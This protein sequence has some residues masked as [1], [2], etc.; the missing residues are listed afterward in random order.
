MTPQQQPGSSPRHGPGDR[1][2]PPVWPQGASGNGLAARP[3]HLSTWPAP[4][5]GS[6][7]FGYAKPCPSANAALTQEDPA[8]LSRG[9]RTDHP[10]NTRHTDGQRHAALLDSSTA[11][12]GD[13]GAGR[14]P[15][16]RASAGRGPARVPRQRRPPSVSGMTRTAGSAW[17][18]NTARTAAPLCSSVETRT[19]A[20]AA[21]TTAG[22]STSPA[23][24]PT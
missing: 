4:A 9:E 12:P 11:C 8:M 2:G 21:F 10:G 13:R 14:R 23:H 7:R 17:W 22:N 16:A 3:S 18:T 20:Y 15:S 6:T 1:S 5:L 19:A 24:A